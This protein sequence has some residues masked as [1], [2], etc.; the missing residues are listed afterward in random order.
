MQKESIYRLVQ[1]S[2][3]DTATAAAVSAAGGGGAVRRG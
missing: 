1:S 2:D 3:P